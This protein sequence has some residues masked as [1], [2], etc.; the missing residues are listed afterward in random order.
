MSDSQANRPLPSAIVL[1]GPT[2]SGKTPLGEELQRSGLWGRACV[3]FDFGAMLRR[4]ASDSSFPVGDDDR[5]LVRSVLE[6]NRL[7]EDDEWPVVLRLLDAYFEASGVG[8]GDL[9]LM[10]GLPRT[11]GQAEALM[12]HVRVAALIQLCCDEAAVRERVL[13]D[14]GGD[15]AERADDSAVEVS[16]KLAWYRDRTAPLVDFY[17]SRGVCVIDVDVGGTTSTQDV[18]DSIRMHPPACD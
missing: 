17:R 12:A 10:N 13:S 6:A 5:D 7:F 18:A 2:A 4:A 14:T 15:R 16:R 1:L 11:R 9:V 3:H 8:Y